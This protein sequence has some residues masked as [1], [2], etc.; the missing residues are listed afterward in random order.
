MME[1]ITRKKL[2][3]IVICFLISLILFKL[4]SYIG[5]IDL[6]RAITGNTLIFFVTSIAGTMLILAICKV[7]E[8]I[9]F[10]NKLLEYIGNKS[11]FIMVI[12]NYLLLNNLLL[13]ISTRSIENE[14]VALFVATI[15]L[16][17]IVILISCP[18]EPYVNK[19]IKRISEKIVKTWS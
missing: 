15:L 11:L 14:N 12:H 5:N 10:L 4:C 1:Y 3:S 18:L 8:E 17:I 9:N 7:I 19:C 13:N 6:H 16:I 2:F